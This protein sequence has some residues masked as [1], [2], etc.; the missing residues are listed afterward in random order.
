MTYTLRQ[1]IRDICTSSLL[2]KALHL[3]S[4]TSSLAVEGLAE[5]RPSVLVGDFIIVKHHDSS[6]WYKGC[7]HKVSVDT[8][9]L[10]FDSTFSTYKGNRFDVRFVLNRLPHRRM[11]QALTLKVDSTRF[12]FPEPD[13]VGTRAVSAE[14][15]VAITP[16]N[17]LIGENHEQL[18]TVA[19]IV[20]QPPGSVPFIIFGPLVD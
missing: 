1:I 11:H 15:S 8:V 20:N 17:R 16:I 7:V 3:I 14:Q 13:H 10:R 12:L 6:E 2:R 18:M 9:N 19:A 4:R 5:G